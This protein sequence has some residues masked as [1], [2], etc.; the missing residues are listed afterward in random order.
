MT[1]NNHFIRKIVL[2]KFHNI[3]GQQKNMVIYFGKFSKSFVQKR[4]FLKK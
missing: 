2:H 4:P 3:V 1:K